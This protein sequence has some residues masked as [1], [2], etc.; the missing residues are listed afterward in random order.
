MRRKNS[1]TALLLLLSVM[2]FLPG[3]WCCASPI[4]EISKNQTE[5]SLC[6]TTQKHSPEKSDSPIAPENCRCCMGKVFSNSGKTNLIPTQPALHFDRH[7][8]TIT[9]KT[10]LPDNSKSTLFHS[11]PLH[12][13]LC[14]WI[15]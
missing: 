5:A 2:L 11:H 7:W 1:K 15:C 8:E 14:V 9:F 12:V 3:E 13:L 4:K 6:C 10:G